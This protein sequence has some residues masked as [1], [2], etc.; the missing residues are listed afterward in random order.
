MVKNPRWTPRAS[1]VLS[2]GARRNLYGLGTGLRRALVGT[3]MLVVKMVMT[4]LED[5]SGEGQRHGHGSSTVR[6]G[7]GR[8]SGAVVFGRTPDIEGDR[9]ADRWCLRP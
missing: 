7:D 3:S 2:L 4:H 8:R 5:G 1:L 9:R 6:A